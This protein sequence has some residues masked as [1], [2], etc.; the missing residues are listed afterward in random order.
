MFG[1]VFSLLLVGFCFNRLSRY[2]SFLIILG[3]L[4][5]S[6]IFCS[7]IVYEVV[8]LNSFCLIEL[9]SWFNLGVLNVKW[10]FY[11]DKLST[12]MLFLIIFISL[13]VHF[14]ALDY[15][16]ED[17]HLS[18]FLMLLTLFTIF[19][20]ILVTSGNLIQFFFG[21]EGVGLMSYLLINFWFTRYAASNSGLMAIIYNRIGD[22]DFY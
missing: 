6:L 13:L 7:F 11:F 3:S 12:L 20:E 19:M 17:P 5:L 14:F 2:F 9:N 8:Y 10:S 22:S 16:N 15:L 18:R 21:W 4:F 1:P